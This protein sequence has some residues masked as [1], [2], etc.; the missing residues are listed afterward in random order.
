[1][2]AFA[3]HFDHI[4]QFQQVLLSTF[5]VMIEMQHCNV[6]IRL[7][8][9]E[10]LQRA[11]VETFNIHLNH[12]NGLFTYVRK[13]WIASTLVRLENYSVNFLSKLGLHRALRVAFHSRWGKSRTLQVGGARGSPVMICIH[14]AIILVRVIRYG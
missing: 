4:I 10:I 3:D 5:G 11:L 12:C 9:L 2:I 8:L 14:H 1:M 6:F 7:L 13:L